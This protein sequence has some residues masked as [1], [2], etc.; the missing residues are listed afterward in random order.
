MTA[1]SKTKGF[2]I[3][4]IASVV[5]SILFWLGDS[6]VRATLWRHDPSF[7]LL[8]VLNIFLLESYIVPF[9]S[10]LT[11]L[12]LLIVQGKLKRNPFIRVVAALF[13][14]YLGSQFIE[15]SLRF[16]VCY[17]GPVEGCTESQVYAMKKVAL[18]IALF[19]AVTSITIER[20]LRKHFT[21]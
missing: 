7:G 13:L 4:L 1:S 17:G 2:L 12:F 5:P 20:F 11:I 9:Y 19:C 10:F 16:T 14:S 21:A 18:G 8:R 6:C 3:Y 15:G